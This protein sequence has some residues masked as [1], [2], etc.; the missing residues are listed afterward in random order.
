MVKFENVE[1]TILKHRWSFNYYMFKG[2]LYERT[3]KDF[4]FGK[5]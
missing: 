4:L 5:T 3:T 1:K 2:E